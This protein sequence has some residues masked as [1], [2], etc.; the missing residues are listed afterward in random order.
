MVRATITETQRASYRATVEF[1]VVY[2]VDGRAGMRGA[3][4]EGLSVNGFRISGDEDLPEGTVLEL[5]FTL[6]NELIHGVHVEKEIVTLT[7]RGR[8][9][10]KIM[11]PPEPFAEMRVRAKVLLAYF[12]VRRRAIGHSVQF[13]DIV[14]RTQEEIQRFI[15]VWQLHVIRERAAMRGE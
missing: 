2:V 14:E 13:V 8:E 6:P 3:T 10:K 9:T 11:V 5:R 4:A 15:H 1:P 12:N 7:P